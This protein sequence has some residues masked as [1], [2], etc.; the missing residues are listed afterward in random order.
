MKDVKLTNSELQ[1]EY[2]HYNTY[3]PSS[4]SY[5]ETAG[6]YTYQTRLTE[7]SFPLPKQ[8]VFSPPW[9]QNN[10]RVSRYEPGFA[11]FEGLSPEP[12]ILNN[13]A[14][15]RK[16]KSDSRTSH[17]KTNSRSS[18]TMTEP[19]RTD[20]AVSPGWEHIV[21]GKGGLKT[22]SERKCEEHHGTGG[23]RKRK[24]EK[25]AKEKAARVRKVKA[26]WNCWL[27]KVPVSDFKWDF[28]VDSY[29]TKYFPL[30]SWNW[31]RL[32]P[33]SNYRVKWLPRIVDR[34]KH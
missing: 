29:G 33:S 20:K 25:E 21:I 15:S 5:Q 19:K 26:C 17:K 30:P 4:S 12:E 18:N 7:S 3:A 22:V 32:D 2:D 6:N 34:E 10:L 11:A 9:N 24:L 31:F 23:R 13:V 27:L 28:G 1:L 8:D 16:S 14:S